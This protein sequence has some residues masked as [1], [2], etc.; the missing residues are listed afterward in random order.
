MEIKLDMSRFRADERIAMKYR[1]I[2]EGFGYSPYKMSKFEEYDLYA[3]NKDFL[4]DESILTFTDINGKL[5]ALKPDVTLSIV[6]NSKANAG[7]D[8]VYYKENVYR[9]VDGGCFKEILQ[10]GIECIGNIGTYETLEVLILAIKSLEVTSRPFKLYISHMGI[11]SHLIGERLSLSDVK[12]DVLTCIKRK[13]TSGIYEIARALEIPKEDVEPLCR[14]VMLNGSA[15]DVVRSL[16]DVCPPDLAALNELEYICDRL[17]DMGYGDNVGIDV[18]VLNDMNYY[19]SL[20]F[21]GYIDSVPE[22]ILSGGR[23]DDLMKKMGREC[24]AIGFAV[25]LD[26]LEMLGD[27]SARP[28]VDVYAVYDDDTD[29]ISLFEKCEEIRSEGKTVA[30]VSASDVPNNV[31]RVFRMNETREFSMVEVN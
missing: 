30:V 7:T 20:V 22:E 25:S 23:Y 18:S 3:K 5:M 16:K 26:K 17:S 13:N 1:N 8:K 29:M 15:G 12:D 19:R 2:F 4:G 27:S 21:K 28:L 6:K 31:S 24:G 14:A 11:L 10:S 9:R